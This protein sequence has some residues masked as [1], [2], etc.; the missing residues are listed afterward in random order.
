[1][2]T[3]KCGHNCDVQFMSADFFFPHFPS[4][5]LSLAKHEDSTE[6]LKQQLVLHCPLCI[7][8]LQ[9]TD[10]QSSVCRRE[11]AFPQ[12][13]PEFPFAASAQARKPLMQAMKY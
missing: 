10:T 8:T 13:L 12:M 11:L 3:Q 2:S 6:P 7:Q 4:E 5:H 9:H 1:M